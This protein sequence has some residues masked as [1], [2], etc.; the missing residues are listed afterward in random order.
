MIIALFAIDEKGGMGFDGSMP[1][2]RN[3]EDMQ[4]FK[5]LTEHQLVVMGKKTWECTD[6]PVP[7][8]NR[9]NVL[10]TNNFIDREDILQLRGDVCDGL[11][12]IQETY[13]DLDIFVI[14]GPNLLM[15]TIPILQKIFITRIPGEYHCDTAI[16]I[17][18]FL[19][20]FQMVDLKK[21]ET[22]EINEYEAIPTSP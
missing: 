12:S 3:K 16:D 4:W 5:S 22:C 11:L 6:M 21:L 2:P 19:V 9:L 13:P 20:G 17:D 1:W 7:L 14:G 15:Q 8:P 18:K 10:V